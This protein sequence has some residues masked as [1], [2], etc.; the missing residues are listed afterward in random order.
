M[1][2]GQKQKALVG[3]LANLIAL[4]FPIVYAS[5]FSLQ[6]FIRWGYVLIGCWILCA[7]SL[8]LSLFGPKQVRLPMLF[9]SVAVAVFWTMVPLGVL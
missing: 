2:S 8:V 7:L 3:L 9:S 5:T 6:W 4:V 1:T